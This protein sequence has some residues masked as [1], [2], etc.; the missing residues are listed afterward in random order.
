LLKSDSEDDI[1]RF[2]QG[3]FDRLLKGKID[4]D[5][6]HMVMR[7]TDNKLA[8][9]LQMLHMV[10]KMRYNYRLGITKEK[11]SVYVIFR[12]IGD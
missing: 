1:E 8:P 6:C 4:M 10:D 5:D 9:S 7:D 12:G 2:D 3:Q 11:V